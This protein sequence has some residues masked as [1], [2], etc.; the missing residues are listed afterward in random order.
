MLLNQK[1]FFP[2][3]MYIMHAFGMDNGQWLYRKTQ[4]SQNFYFDY[5]FFAQN[6]DEKTRFFGRH[7]VIFALVI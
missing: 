2:K 4:L 6:G 3:S 1:H 5:I 7:F